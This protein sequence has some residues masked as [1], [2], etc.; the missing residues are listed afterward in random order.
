MHNRIHQ[1]SEEQILKS[2]VKS[3]FRKIFFVSSSSNLPWASDRRS[4]GLV[5][6]D[7][8]LVEELLNVHDGEIRL[9]VIAQV[10]GQAI[11]I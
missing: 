6:L 2:G 4:R 8:V 5:H 11:E 3:I 1:K 7:V 10:H 9:L